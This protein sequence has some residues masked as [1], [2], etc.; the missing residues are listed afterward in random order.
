MG[1]PRPFRTLYASGTP[2]EPRV[3]YSRAV[4]AGDEIFVSGTTATDREGRIVGGADVFA[5]TR[6]ALANVRRAVEALGGEISDVV[7]TRVYVRDI[8]SWEGVARAHHELFGEARPATT[9]VEVSGFIDE[10]MLV[11]VEA[12]ARVPPERAQRPGRGSSPA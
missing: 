8:R 6:Q 3:G 10:A 4:R 2:W 1:A 12:D 7:R 5:Q 11:E 9:M